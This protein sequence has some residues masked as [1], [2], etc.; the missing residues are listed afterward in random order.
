[1]GEYFRIQAD[2]R[3]LNYSIY[4]E[5]GDLGQTRYDDYDSHTVDRMSVAEVEDLLVTL[6]EV[7]AELAAAGF[8]PEEVA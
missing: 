1:M 3:D 2:N 6:P 7:R 4:V 8:A 5:E